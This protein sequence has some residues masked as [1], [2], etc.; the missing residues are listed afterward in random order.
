MSDT[1]QMILQHFSCMAKASPL[2]CSGR[3]SVRGET[4]AYLGGVRLRKPATA[5]FHQVHAGTFN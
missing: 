2:H 4:R 5:A 1:E 3:S